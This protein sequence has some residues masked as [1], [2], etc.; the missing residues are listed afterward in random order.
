MSTKRIKKISEL[1][2]KLGSQ[3]NVKG[4]QYIK[5]GIEFCLK[6]PLSV[7]NLKKLIYPKLAEEYKTT[8]DAVEKAARNAIKSGWHRRDK[9][10]T[11]E[12]FG[13]T[14]QSEEDSPSNSLFIAAI[15]EWI[16]DDDDS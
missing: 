4:F 13:N 14:L 2:M 7:T 10:L 11:E 5:R 1:L 3:P 16:S 6:D 8:P 9:K 15:A 12:I